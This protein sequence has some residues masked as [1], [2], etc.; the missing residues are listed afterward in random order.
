[1]PKAENKKSRA[2]EIVT[3]E[4]TINLHK[5][6]HG[7]GFKKR[8]PRAVKEIKKF[9]SKIMGTTDV[10]VDPRLNKFV[11]NQ[12]IRSVPYRVRVRLARKRNDDE[13]AKEK[14]YTLVT[15]VP[16]TSFKGLQTQNVDAE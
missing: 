5:R 13:D 14:L 6:L 15:Y 10:R 9:A 3:R 16:V 4:Y 2:A 12:G 7:V 8:A 1:M 11:W